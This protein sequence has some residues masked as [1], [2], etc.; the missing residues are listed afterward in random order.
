ME[1]ILVGGCGPASFKGLSLSFSKFPILWRGMRY[2]P[3]SRERKPKDI[4]ERERKERKRDTSKT[5]E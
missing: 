1:M 4:L 2:R 3:V 5:Q